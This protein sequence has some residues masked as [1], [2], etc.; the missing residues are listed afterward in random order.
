M[1]NLS[2]AFLNCFPFRFYRCNTAEKQWYR[3]NRLAYSFGLKGGVSRT[4]TSE[5]VGLLCDFV[6]RVYGGKHD[7]KTYFC[8]QYPL[9]AVCSKS[10]S[11]AMHTGSNV[12][13]ELQNNSV[14]MRCKLSILLMRGTV[15]VLH[16]AGF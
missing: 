5:N 4:Y 3:P 15:F 8:A 10:V 6:E 14:I 2:I 13:R 12:I 7:Y 11:L 16:G 9:R 1:L